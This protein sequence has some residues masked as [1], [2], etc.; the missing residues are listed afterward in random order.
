MI[1]YLVLLKLVKEAQ[2][3]VAIDEDMLDGGDI[4]ERLDNI[5]GRYD[6]DDQAELEKQQEEVVDNS[7]P[8]RIKRL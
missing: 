6:A 8:A 3:K 1:I 2:K 5:D 4:E 7:Y